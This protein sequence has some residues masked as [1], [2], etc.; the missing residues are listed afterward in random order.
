VDKV[1]L[2][3]GK[4]RQ[5]AIDATDTEELRTYQSQGHFPAGSMGPKIEAVIEYLERGGR[6][7]IITNHEQLE[8]A[9]GGRAGTHV[10]ASL[11]LEATGGT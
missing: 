11:P 2:D 4:P 7:A 6:R 1:Y 10:K 8:P 3:F 5:R 9:L